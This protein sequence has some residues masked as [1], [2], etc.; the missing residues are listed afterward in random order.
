MKCECLECE[1]DAT[2]K[3]LVGG[4]VINI[5]RGHHDVLVLKVDK[6]INIEREEGVLEWLLKQPSN[7]HKVVKYGIHIIGTRLLR[8]I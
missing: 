2:W 4:K 8:G 3:L 7:H 6:T 5:C 1:N